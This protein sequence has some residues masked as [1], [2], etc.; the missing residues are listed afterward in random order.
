MYS[1]DDSQHPA[2]ESIEA[3]SLWQSSK[4]T[5]SRYRN[6][7]G[8]EDTISSWQIAKVVEESTRGGQN[9]AYI[10]GNDDP[11]NLFDYYDW[12]EF[13]AKL[14]TP[15]PLLTSY[16][17]FQCAHQQPWVV[18]VREFTDSEEK[19]VV[20]KPGI[21]IDK[22]AH[23]STMTPPG[24]SQE[25]MQYTAK[26]CQIWFRMNDLSHWIWADYND[27]TECKSC[28]QWNR[29]VIHSGIKSIFMPFQFCNASFWYR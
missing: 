15:V 28:T 14:F 11:S 6:C 10:I 29:H 23:P 1:T 12:A 24:L 27:D 26:Y 5:A 25:R 7:G 9:R 4:K 18:F 3:H 20:L 17:H 2:S 8:K 13:L 21:A 16:H 22:T 19:I